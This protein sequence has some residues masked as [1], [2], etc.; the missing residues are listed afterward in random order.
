ME[1]YPDPKQREILEEVFK[2]LG[3]AEGLTTPMNLA[4][5]T[6]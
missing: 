6:G 2:L 3:Y 4:V 5:I 1:R